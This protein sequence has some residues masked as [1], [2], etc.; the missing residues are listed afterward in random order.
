MQVLVTGGQGFIGRYVIATLQAQGHTP[1]SFDRARTIAP[2]CAHVLG[3]VRDSV[4]VAESV[5]RVEGVIHLAAVLGTQETVAAPEIAIATNISGSVT[6]FQACARFHVPCVYITVGN[7]WMQNPYSI[8]KTCAERFAWMANQEWGARIAV[9]RALNAYGPGQRA[10]PV[11]KIVPAFMEAARTG[12][13]I[14]IYGDGLQIM[15]MIHVRDVA[16]ILVRALLVPHGQYQTPF[17][18]GTGRRTTVREIAMMVARAGGSAHLPVYLPMR[19]GEPW[20]SVVLGDPETLRPL[21]DGRLPRQ[22]TLEE[23]LA[24]LIDPAG[25]GG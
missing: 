8:T 12:R 10:A 9:V 21:Y 7:H 2:A 5:A 16:D 17:E 19:P 25:S 24:E 20:S 23:G 14:E 15:D 1:V 11:R 6:V 4:A 22:T 3:D 13:A 18:A